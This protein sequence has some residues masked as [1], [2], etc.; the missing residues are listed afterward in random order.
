M[1][2]Y[3]KKRSEFGISI[4]ILLSVTSNPFNENEHIETA[5]SISAILTDYRKHLHYSLN[6]NKLEM[7]E[8]DLE[9][10]SEDPD[11]WFE[12]N[13]YFFVAGYST[14]STFTA[15]LSYSSS[16]KNV[17]KKVDNELKVAVGGFGFGIDFD[18]GYK[19]KANTTSGNADFTSN[20]NATGTN[21]N[22]N[23]MKN[24]ELAHRLFQEG[25]DE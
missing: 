2:N 25:L 10:F 5:N 23:D 21:N 13:G 20:I 22:V 15:I 11:K 7:D 16:N 14:G 6:P 1:I 3:V 9:L 24:V 19:H 8:Y 18:Y 4:F 17:Y 12:E